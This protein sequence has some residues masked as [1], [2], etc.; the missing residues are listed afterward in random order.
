MITI[1]TTVPDKLLNIDK[2]ITGCTSAVEETVADSLRDFE[3]ISAPFDD[4]VQ[5]DVSVKTTGQ[6]VIGTVS[7]DDENLSRLNRGFDVPPV[8]GK[9]MYLYPGYASKTFPNTIRSRR[10][11]NV[12]NRI[13]RTRRRGFSVQARHF[14]LA[15]ANNNRLKFFQRVANATKEASR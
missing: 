15:V 10:G 6:S 8:V 14:D 11:G 2:L 12:G 5:Y 1:K 7:T 4:P 3:T 13:I 9:V